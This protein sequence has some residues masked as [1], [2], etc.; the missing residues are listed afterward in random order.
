MQ[1]ICVITA[2]GHLPAPDE[3][4]QDHKRISDSFLKLKHTCR[5]STTA[6]ESA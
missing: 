6:T 2:V 5:R 1:S 3:D 4:E